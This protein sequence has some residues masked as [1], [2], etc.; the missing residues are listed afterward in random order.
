[1]SIDGVDDE[2]RSK[3]CPVQGGQEHR[4][5]PK[6]KSRNGELDVRVW[7]YTPKNFISSTDR[8]RDSS[9]E[10]IWSSSAPR[11]KKSKSDGRSVMERSN[12]ILD[13]LKDV[14]LISPL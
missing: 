9:E 4:R 10:G 14:C 2:L 7:S 3:C 13:L 1:M 12:R 5:H 6:R 11:A 8:D